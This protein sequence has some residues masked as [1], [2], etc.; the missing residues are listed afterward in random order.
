MSDNRSRFALVFRPEGVERELPAAA[1]LRFAMMGANR[2]H[3][4]TPEAQPGLHGMLEAVSSHTG[5]ATPVA[6]VWE[7]KKPVANAVAMP[8]KVPVVAFSK[9]ITEILN[10]EELAAVTAHELGHVKNQGQFGKLYW[11]SAIGGATLAYLGAKPIQSRIREQFQKGK[12]NPALAMASAAVEASLF[13]A[14]AA[15]A[16]VAS[17]SEELAADRHAAYALDG[18]AVP[19]VSALEKLTEFNG[20]G[21]TPSKN[22][23]RRVLSSHPSYEQRREALGVSQESVQNYRAEQEF[24]IPQ[25]EHRFTNTIQ[26]KAPV[27]LTAPAAQGDWQERVSAQA[28]AAQ[29]QGQNPGRGQ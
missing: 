27:N 9:S 16:A 28:D 3:A 14:P 29:T 4:V 2:L 1:R 6:F 15:A 24:D 19:L 21:K 13:V 23:L 17:R 18:N 20:S 12:G 26:P 25:E 8:G 10:T 11:L 7:S 5:V 22:P